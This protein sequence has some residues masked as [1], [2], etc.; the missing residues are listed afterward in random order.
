MNQYRILPADLAAGAHQGAQAAPGGGDLHGGTHGG[1][2]GDD[3]EADARH[4][5][6]AQQAT[7]PA[8]VAGGEGTGRRGPARADAGGE[9]GGGLRPVHSVALLGVGKRGGVVG[10][11]NGRPPALGRGGGEVVG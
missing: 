7:A 2:V 3:T 8:L 5:V 10:Q 4:P 11:L 1:G 6:L 9:V